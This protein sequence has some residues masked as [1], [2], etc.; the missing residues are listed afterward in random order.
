MPVTPARAGADYSLEISFA[1]DTLAPGHN[2][3]NLQDRFNKADWSN[4]TQTNDYS[5]TGAQASSAPSTRV[6]AYYNGS[7]VWDTEP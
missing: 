2:T 5:S 3:G 7:L 1:A 6:T 4:D